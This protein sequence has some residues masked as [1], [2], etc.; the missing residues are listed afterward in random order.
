MCC[1]EGIRKM[2][3]WEK[4]CVKKK[5]KAPQF[6]DFT[7]VLT[8]INVHQKKKKTLQ[9]I[10]N[11]LSNISGCVAT[12]TAGNSP[13]TLLKIC[14]GFMFFKDDSDGGLSLCCWLK[15]PGF[16]L[17]I[18][19]TSRRTCLVLLPLHI[20]GKCPDGLWTTSSGFMP[21]NVETLSWTLV[22]GLAWKYLVFCCKLPQ[23]LV[24]NMWFCRHTQ[25]EVALFSGFT[26]GN[27]PSW[28]MVSRVAAKHTLFV[29]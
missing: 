29:H 1:Q 3:H 6:P 5:K 21:R 8:R 18:I 26:F 27:I 22:S 24:K 2:T 20:A 7:S 11:I 17:H 9:I 4:M 28:T 14:S 16:L 13:A 10:N 25:L 19:P 15:I 23:R 12:Y